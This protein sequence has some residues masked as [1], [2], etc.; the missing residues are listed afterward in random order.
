M[1][2]VECMGAEGLNV[3]GLA[4]CYVMPATSPA[5]SG[6]SQPGWVARVECGNPGG[7]QQGLTL[8]H[9]PRDS[10]TLGGAFSSPQ[11]GTPPSVGRHQLERAWAAAH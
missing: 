3:W 4:V 7:V 10:G 11:C 1:G 6:Y 9:W 2:P 8:G 5:A